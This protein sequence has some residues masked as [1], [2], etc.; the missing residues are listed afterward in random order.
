MSQFVHQPVLLHETIGELVT[1]K[2][3]IYVDCTLG[4]GGHTEAILKTCP[5]ARVIGIDQD[6]E[7]IRASSERLAPYGDRA[8]FVWNN[9]SDL[10]GVLAELNIERADGFLFDL[11]ISSPQLDHGERGFSYQHDA[12]LDMRMNRDKMQITAKDIV[13]TY[14]AE[15]ITDII[16]RYGE[17]RWAKRIAQFICE[18]RKDAPIETTGELVSVI[19]AAIPKKVREDGHH[20]AKKTFQALRIAVNDELNIIAPAMEEAAKHL[21]PGGKLAVISFHSLEDRIVKETMKYLA[22]DCIC[23][24]ESIICT[25]NKERLIKVTVRKPIVAG[26]EELA[27]N[28]RARSAK[29]RVGTRI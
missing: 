12:P 9:F 1:K 3:G 17:E 19:K 8:V 20:P 15:E 16:Y 7:A 4:G 25:C 27:E 26:A 14:S 11:G 28:P 5:E 10:S 23:P 29:L 6:M 13:N 22:K 2:D 21:N 18:R 24:P